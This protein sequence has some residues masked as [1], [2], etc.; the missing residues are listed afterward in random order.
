VKDLQPKK[1]ASDICG[2]RLFNGRKNKR[3][4]TFKLEK[5]TLE[6][7]LKFKSQFPKA[8]ARKSLELEGSS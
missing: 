7:A 1:S 5:W 2:G 8:G 3:K 4:D 6:K